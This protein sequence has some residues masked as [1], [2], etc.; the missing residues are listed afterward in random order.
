MGSLV[1]T[2]GEGVA[3]VEVWA[4][5]GWGKPTGEKGVLCNLGKTSNLSAA[6]RYS[7]LGMRLTPASGRDRLATNPLYISVYKFRLLIYISR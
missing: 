6:V 3:M 5:E 7:V 1:T 4:R 2:A